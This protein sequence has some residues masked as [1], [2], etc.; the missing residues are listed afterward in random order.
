MEAAPIKP[1]LVVRDMYLLWNGLDSRSAHS[2]REPRGKWWWSLPECGSPTWSADFN[3][4]VRGRAHAQ[5]KLPGVGV[6]L[7]DSDTFLRVAEGIALRSFTCTARNKC[8]I[9]GRSAN[10][11]KAFYF[12]SFYF[13]LFLGGYKLLKPM[14][15]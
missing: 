15:Q 4:T 10:S 14:F 13:I 6:G 8:V 2:L 11:F 9:P 5:A 7:G 3:S 1:M 12:I